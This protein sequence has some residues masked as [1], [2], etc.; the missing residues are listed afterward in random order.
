VGVGA[1]ALLPERKGLGFVPRK[2]RANAEVVTA[3]RL[4]GEWYWR[5][6]GKEVDAAA[7]IAGEAAAVAKAIA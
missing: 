4:P 2:R 3:R 6:D 7:T 5:R 1:A